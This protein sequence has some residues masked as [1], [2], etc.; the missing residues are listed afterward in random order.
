MIKNPAPKNSN[1][2]RRVIRKEVVPKEKAKKRD[3][4]FSK[5]RDNREDRSQRQMKNSKNPR[6]FSHGN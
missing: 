5:S 1:D 2:K 4:I 3:D 6:T